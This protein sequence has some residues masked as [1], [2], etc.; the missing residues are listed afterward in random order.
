MFS[1]FRTAIVLGTAIP[2]GLFLVWDGV[3]LGSIS[4][5]EMADKIADPLQQLLSTNGVVGVSVFEKL[6]TS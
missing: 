1:I 6:L 4:T 5:P 2:L 3:I